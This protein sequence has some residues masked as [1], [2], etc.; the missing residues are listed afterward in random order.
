MTND[1]HSPVER[2]V[3]SVVGIVA[4]LLGVLT[5]LQEQVEYALRVCSLLIGIAV[6]AVA[7]YRALKNP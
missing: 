6:G 5:S 1:P 7:L 4:P 2:T 3:D